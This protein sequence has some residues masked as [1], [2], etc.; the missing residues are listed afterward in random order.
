VSAMADPATA[1]SELIGMRRG[2]L[3]GARDCGTARPGPGA[4]TCSYFTDEAS[5]GQTH[6]AAECSC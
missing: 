2:L 5:E 6:A 1:I 3:S 4:Q